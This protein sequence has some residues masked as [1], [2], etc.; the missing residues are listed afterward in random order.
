MVFTAL[1]AAL[2]IAASFIKIPLPFSPVPITLQSFAVMIAGGLLGAVYGFWSIFI[3]IILT[4][5]GFQLMNG[6]GGFAQIL[7]P[8][9]GFIWMFPFAALLIGWFSDKLFSGKKKLTIAQTV[10]LLL[11]VYAFGS[12][13]LYV[14]GVPWLAHYSPKY[15]LHGAYMAGMYPFFIGDAIKAAAAALVIKALR[16]TLPSIRPIKNK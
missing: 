7:G 4:A 10:W 14:T 5:C 15:D 16:P 9:G 8:T 2:F 1:F 11:A 13:L 12:L 3:V 6:P